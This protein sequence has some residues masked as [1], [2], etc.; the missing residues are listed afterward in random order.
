MRKTDRTTK[1]IETQKSIK[2]QNQTKKRKPANIFKQMEHVKKN[3][4]KDRRQQ[5][6]RC[7]M[8][9][10]KIKNDQTQRKGS[11]S[12]NNKLQNKANL[13][14]ELKQQMDLNNANKHLSTNIASNTFKKNRKT[15]KTQTNTHTQ[16]RKKQHQKHPH[17]QR[18]KN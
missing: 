8:M 6:H 5:K 1:H 15:N 9:R 10:E 4:S 11:K 3:M 16:N 13:T 12:K 18:A 2:R 7:T 17:T 14:T